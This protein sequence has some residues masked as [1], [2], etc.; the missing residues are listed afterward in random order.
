MR[1][2]TE[3]FA[4][5]V[6]P[7]VAGSV[8]DS[9]VGPQDVIVIPPLPKTFSVRLAE[10]MGCALLESVDEFH[11]VTRVGESLWKKVK[12]VRHNAICMKAKAELPSDC[13][14]F[15]E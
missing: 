5:W 1:A 6:P 2:G 10:F 4:Y 9:F 7:N 12:M 3:P 13:N 11:Q 14:Q 8:F 15:F